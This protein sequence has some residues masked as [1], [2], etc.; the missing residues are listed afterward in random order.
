MRAKSLLAVLATVICAG[1]MTS[2][3]PMH[4][5]DTGATKDKELKATDAGGAAKKV[6]AKDTNIKV[7][8]PKADNPKAKSEDPRKGKRGMV[9]DVRVANNTPWHLH[10]Y[11][12]GEYE[13]TLSPWCYVDMPFTA[14][15]VTLYGKVL[16]DNGTE[17]TWGPRSIYLNEGQSFSWTCA[18]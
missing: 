16:F 2:T 8:A 7:D 3:V 14:G 15:R 9:C 10:V 17:T 6:E 4:A 11:T 1:A 12:N 18:Q 13:G 5:A